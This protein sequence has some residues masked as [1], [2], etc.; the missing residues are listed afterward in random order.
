MIWF[1]P[2]KISIVTVN[3]L[4]PNFL[5]LS[6]D[7]LLFNFMAKEVEGKKGKKRKAEE[8]EEA[9][10]KSSVSEEA[11]EG[12]VSTSESESES[13]PANTK[14]N[15]HLSSH[16]LMADSRSATSSRSI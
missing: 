12:D 1:N 6:I 14:V 8:V 9:E 2:A 3:K 16:Q 7:R 5:H 4:T 15:H 13:E 10:T 11:V